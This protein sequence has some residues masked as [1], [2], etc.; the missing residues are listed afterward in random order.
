MYEDYTAMCEALAKI[1]NQ[2]SKAG[3]PKALGPMVFAVT[4]TGRVAQGSIE[5]LVQFPHEMVEPSQLEELHKD[6]NWSNKK[7]YIVTF[8]SKD[9]VRRKDGGEFEKGHYYKHPQEY[10][11]IFYE[12]LQYVSFLV[13]CIYWEPRFPRVLTKAELKDAVQEERN[14]LMG[15]CDISADYEGSI[16]FTSRFTSIE[17]PFLVYDSIKGD[18]KEKISEASGPGDVLFHSVDHLPA[19]MP[20]EASNHFGDKMFPFVEAIVN[21]NFDLP[22]EE[23]TDLPEEIRNAVITVGGKLAPNYQYIQV[24]RERNEDLKK[25][26][27]QFEAETK[28]KDHEQLARSMSSATL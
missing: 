6:G 4:G 2:I 27:E 17:E 3:L 22:F 20:V 21:S 26:E 14:K 11:P 1:G 16:E 15:V 19:E 9:L 28:G 25:Q 7:I 24:L 23:Q 18:W 13:E 8:V 5:I 12:Y 10:E